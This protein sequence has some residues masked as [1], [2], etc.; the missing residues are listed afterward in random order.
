MSNNFTNAFIVF[1]SGSVLLHSQSD[2][3]RAEKPN[4]SPN[5]CCEKFFSC[6]YLRIFVPNVFI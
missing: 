2:T 4:I 5:F 6:L 1:T 3:V